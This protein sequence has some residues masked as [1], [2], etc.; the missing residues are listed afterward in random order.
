MQKSLK[1]IRKIV[2][3]ILIS[4]EQARSDDRYLYI[5]VVRKINPSL[6]WEP[7][8]MA[9]AEADIPNY[10]TVRRN[11]QWI[12]MKYPE[13]C[14]NDEVEAWREIHRQTYHDYFRKV[15]E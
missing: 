8:V 9:F 13:L 15:T 6:L 1:Q 4:D 3:S 12:Q 5:E 7:L 11:R 2:K 10:E 14:G